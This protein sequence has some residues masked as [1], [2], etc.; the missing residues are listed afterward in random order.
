MWDICIE[1]GLMLKLKLKLQ[2]LGQLIWRADHW[3]RPR[4]WERL[5]ARGEGGNRG[6]D[7]WMKSPIQWTWVWAN[8]GRWWGTGKPGMLQSTGSQR[9]GHNWVIEQQRMH[10]GDTRRGENFEKEPGRI[11][12][13]MMTKIW[14]VW[15]EKYLYTL[16]RS[17]ENSN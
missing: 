5:R 8:S 9:V 15:N 14:Q 7:D 11:F 10:S 13:K 1:E 3:K 16:P 17:T 4:C 12:E 6:W 2:D